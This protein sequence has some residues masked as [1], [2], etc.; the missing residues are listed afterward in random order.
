MKYTIKLL[1]FVVCCFTYSSI[2]SQSDLVNVKVVIKNE[3]NINTPYL[4]YSPSFYRDGVVFV[5]NKKPGLK[6]LRRDVSNKYKTSVRTTTSLFESRRDDAGVNQAPNIFAEELTTTYHEGPVTFS[7]DGNTIYFTR[8]NYLNTVKG[9]SKDGV[10]KLKIY[11]ADRQGNHWVNKREVQGIENNAEYNTSNPTLSAD[12][13]TL[14]FSSDRPGG[15]GGYDIY[16]AKKSGSGWGSVTNLGANVNTAKTEAFPFVHKDGFL[17]FTSN[18]YHEDA[19]RSDYDLYLIEPVGD[20]W[21]TPLNLEV[22]NTGSDDFSLILNDEKT[23]GYF[24]S[25]R[26]HDDAKGEDDIYSFTSEGYL[27][28]AEEAPKPTTC[29]VKVITTDAQTGDV[30]TDTKVDYMKLDAQAVTRAIVGNG[31]AIELTPIDGATN[32][33]NLKILFDGEGMESATTNGQGILEGLDMCDDYVLR[34]TKEGYVPQQAVY[35]YSEDGE[36]PVVNIQMTRLLEALNIDG[37]VVDK[38]TQSGISSPRVS[39][40]NKTTGERMA[41]FTGDANGNFVF[42]ADCGNTYAIT[43]KAGNYKAYT[44]E[45]TLEDQSCYNKKKVELDFPLDLAIGS[46][47]TGTRIPLNIYYDF[48]DSQIRSDAM[49]ELD[50]ILSLLQRY[51]YLTV[52][53][54]S[55]TDTRGGAAYN[56]RLSD[57]RAQAARQYLVNKGIASNRVSASGFGESQP[58]FNC[59]NNCT[60]AEHQTNRRTTA[61]ISQLNTLNIGTYD[62]PPERVDPGE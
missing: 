17:I 41:D 29:P 20:E 11:M 51:P 30:I 46:G 7:R 38:Q 57:R 10:M 43:V 47:I 26:P 1:F 40:L 12:G 25:N 2:F 23:G 45:F 3:D 28:I 62:N 58:K 14:Y 6:F 24:S 22:F 56:Q 4:E 37:A 54:E 44:E 50:Q 9:K 13:N 32:E 27:S 19:S 48:N 53:L 60:E 35:T 52:R 8:D 16:S 55:H 15:Q 34:A 21:T 61:I 42:A 49:N 5:S 18:G 39:I 36:D 59:G 33:Y 31:N